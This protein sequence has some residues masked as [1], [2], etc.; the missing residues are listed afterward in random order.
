MRRS[1]LAAVVWWLVAAGPAA[2]GR[3]ELTVVA[4]DPPARSI[5]APVL[6]AIA[7][8]FDRP[9]DPATVTSGRFWAFGRWSGTAAGTRSVSGDGLTV[10][11]DPDAPLS[12]G[13]NVHV[14]LSTELA[15]LDG[16]PMR[17]GGFAYQFWTAAAPAGLDLVE[18]DRLTT[19]T[20][21]EEPSRA[22]GGFAGDLDEDGWLDLTIVNED[23]S[24]LRVFLNRADGSGLYDDFL[25][26]TEPTGNVP[27][28]SET[29]DF[30][31]D[32]HTD[33]AV[34]N[35]AGSSV[36][37]LLGNGDGTFAPH[38]EIAL[39]A[40]PR[41]IAVLDLDGD[42]DLD[43]AAA[44]IGGS[45]LV[46]LFND[47]GGVFGSPAPFGAGDGS[48]WA[49]AAGDFTEDGLLDLVVGT[50]G[51]QRARVWAG[52]GDGTVALVSDQP[53]GGAAWMIA[54]G[55]VDGDGHEDV[56]V[57]NG[58][59][60]EGAILLG[61][62]TGHLGAPQEHPVDPQVLATD[63]GDLDGDGDLDWITASFFGD[64]TLFVNDGAGSFTF[65]REIPATRAAS[66]SLM[67]DM[68][69][70]GDLDLALIDELEDE[71]ILLHSTGGLFADGFESGDTAAWTTT[72]R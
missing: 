47:G 51:G 24:D 32:G 21:P 18:V 59:S 68:D 25:Q 55:D 12:A 22:Y 15:G 69:R 57:A 8:T 2:A 1:W 27:S 29:G 6:G 23:T 41:G 7:V 42:A 70:D 60:D 5:G 67:L 48:P 44:Q 65:E 49:L 39:A 16:S 9:V 58:S 61:D 19:R 11:L 14:L 53:I 45:D 26:P 43:V 36:S 10:T 34:A 64:F 50:Q 17:P 56:S 31:L 13:E 40:S 35:T 46:L 33:V 72:T 63:L 38:Q 71:V 28:P 4:T 52:R 3:E 62:G 66:C 37:I 30:D 54:V 20:A